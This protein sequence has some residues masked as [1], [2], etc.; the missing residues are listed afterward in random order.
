MTFPVL[1]S[2]KVALCALLLA[3]PLGIVVAWMQSRAHYFGKR[4]VDAVILLPLVLPPSVIGY[5]LI[6]WLGR[7]GWVGALLD[8]WGITLAFTPWAAVI[9]SAVVSFPI[10]VKT[11]QPA[12]ES[13]SRDLQDVGRTLGLPPTSVFLRIVLPCAWRGVL[14]ATALGFAR[15]IGEFGATLMFAGYAPGATNTMPLEIYFAYQRGDDSA[16]WLYVGV[17]SLVSVLIVAVASVLTP[18]RVA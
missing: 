17:L 5:F 9:A 14:A 18:R 12:I 8:S 13:V 2:L 1:L 16:A 6:V 4:L 15:G 11:A 10:V 3:A 7:S